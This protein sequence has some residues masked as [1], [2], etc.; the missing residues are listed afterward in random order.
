MPIDSNR[1]DYLLEAYIKERC[2]EAERLELL[3][4]IHDGRDQDLV[5][6]WMDQS[7][8]HFITVHQLNEQSAEQIFNNILQA[9]PAA[10]IPI[11][12][13]RKRTRIP[14]V[15]WAAAAILVAVGFGTLWLFHPFSTTPPVAKANAVHNDVAPGATRAMLTL[16]DGRKI[17]VDTAANGTLAVQDQ[18]TVVNS[19]G[20]L[21][22]QGQ[23]ASSVIYNTL[24]TGRG[25]QSPPLTL[26]DGTKVW[27]DAA[28]SIRFPVAFTGK[29]RV[30][31]ITGQP[32][33]E[34]AKN[35]AMPF[36][37]KKGGLEIEVLGTH[38]NV[39]AYEDNADTR[40]TLLE[41]SVRV[42]KG[43]RTAI[44]KPGEQAVVAGDAVTTAQADIAS[45]MAWKDGLFSFNDADLPAIMKQLARWY[46]VD[47]VYEGKMAPRSF[48]GKMQ[49]DLNL[50]TV[51]HSLEKN[52][53]HFRIEGRKIIVLP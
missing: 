41:G 9:G 35:T 53:V 14:P 17:A 20:H 22:Y 24:S 48:G 28:S 27:L 39:N 21:N 49:R 44:I 1:L 50:S 34:V 10:V 31:E 18:T 45:V 4:L 32:Y 29:Q 2:S 30:V 12:P 23:Q 42:R 37:V 13:A 47:V 15:W 11:H 25:E 38:F 52:N 3:Q 5:R 51:L 36:I 26:S 7:R 40:V 43:E 19:N 8:R 16:A 6:E 46:D 33:F